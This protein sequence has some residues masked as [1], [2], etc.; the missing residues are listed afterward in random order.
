MAVAFAKRQARLIISAR[1]EEE[2]I[3]VQKEC[4]KYT[5][6]CEVAPFDLTDFEKLNETSTRILQKYNAI[7]ILVNNGGVS[8]RSEAIE[9]SFAVDR[10][11]MDLNYFS[12]VALTKN[13]L[14]SMMMNQ[15]GHIVVISSVSGKFGFPLRSAYA[16]SKHALHG[17][18][19]T[20]RFEMHEHN[21]W[22]TI[23]CPGRI[24]TNISY[25]AL[26][27]DGK[28]HGKMDE[29]QENG[30]TAEACAEK[31]LNAISKNKKEIYIGGKEILMVYFKRFFPG[32]FNY[33]VLKVR[34]T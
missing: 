12:Y 3:R 10:R 17:F 29:G 21:I 13:I 8:Q 34:P 18:F 28:P 22:V 6:D 9:A 32:L 14:P 16:A 31:I 27:K 15:K 25:H 30:I 26:D 20:L 19:D 2:L 4:L 33:L 5:V 1:R 7:D 24:K 23:V 11:I